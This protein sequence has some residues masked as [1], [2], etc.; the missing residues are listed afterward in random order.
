MTFRCRISDEYHVWP[1]TIEGTE[2]LTAIQH[3]NALCRHQAGVEKGGNASIPG[4][5][6]GLRPWLGSINSP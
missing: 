3:G 4:N 6:L 2:I 5:D 1:M